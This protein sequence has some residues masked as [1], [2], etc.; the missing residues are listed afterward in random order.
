MLDAALLFAGSA[1]VIVAA[2]MALAR[3]ADRIADLTGLGRLLVGG[4]FLAGATSLPELMV[5]LNSVWLGQP[6]LAVGDLLG[7]SLLNLLILAG[8]DMA[9]RGSARAFTQDSQHH[10]LSANG[11]MLLTALAGAGIAARSP[12]AIFGVGPFVW[13]VA[14]AYVLGL[15]MAF[16]ERGLDAP[17]NAP[18][19]E[20]ESAQERR[21]K[22]IKAFA[23]YTACALVILIAAPRLAKAADSLAVL[24]G[25]GHTFV[26]TTLLALATSLP[27]L[28][29]CWAAFRDKATDLALG[30]IF[31]S[32]AFNMALLLPLDAAQPG[33]LLSAVQPLHAV[34]AF[35]VC[36]VTGIAVS[37]QVY[38]RKDRERF[39]EPGAELMIA[40]ILAFLFLI[41]RLNP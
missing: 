32:N 27:E 33:P 31:G 4:I 26:G 35:C 25:L 16:R 40:S 17:G 36:A 18:P 7:S 8:L 28:V 30:N 11:A 24:T 22:L 13:A 21:M 14:A 38:R 15:R 19:P 23:G 1:A 3:F 29:T 37:G 5:D 34:T 12:S 10:A 20:R 39:L 2:G 41:Y 9:F 6:D